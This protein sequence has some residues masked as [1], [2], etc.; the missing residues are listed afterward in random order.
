VFR[1]DAVTPP[2]HAALAI[3]ASIVVSGCGV[4]LKRDLVATTFDNYGERQE[5]IEATLEVLDRHPEYTDE[6]FAHALRHPATLDRF[7]MN[8]T[9]HL[10]DPEMAAL[11]ARYLVRNPRGLHEILVQTLDAARGTEPKRAIASAI[12]DRADK[13]MAAIASD[14]AAEQEVTRAF[15]DIV[16]RSP[17][18]RKPFLAG[19]ARRQAEMATTIASD[20]AVLRGMVDALLRIAERNPR[21]AVLVISQTVGALRSPGFAH[22]T[23]RQLAAHPSTLAEVLLQ[24]VGAVGDHPA[25]GAAMASAIRRR[26]P[27]VASII[28]AHPEALAEVTRAM[29]DTVERDPA[30]RRT[31]VE[32]V[33]QKRGQLADMIMS[34]PGATASL[35][36]AFA[37]RIAKSG[38]IDARL[39]SLFGAAPPR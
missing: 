17:E 38:L 19:L 28:A 14:P 35:V 5:F 15:V 11:T 30:A 23:A 37:G 31:F 36:K 8:T 7:V 22:I 24:T 25:A 10:S 20:P 29:V 33:R 21:V 2:H 39:R 1:F 27:Q 18:A 3:A 34:D 9:A 32:V 6:F 16:S 26:A 4:T 12:E 13:A